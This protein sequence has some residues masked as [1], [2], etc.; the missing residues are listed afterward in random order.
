M[1]LSARLR[2]SA[3]DLLLG[4]GVTRAQHRVHSLVHDGRLEMF[5]QVDDPYSYLLL[6]ALPR[7]LDA[8][9]RLSVDLAVVPAPEVPLD[10]EPELR[11]RYA[12]R[13][14]AEIAARYDVVFP[15]EAEPIDPELAARAAA[16]LAVRRPDRE[17]LTLAIEVTATLW[18]RDRQDL[19][20]LAREHGTVND[21]SASLERAK[22]KQRRRGH[23]QGGMIRYGGTWYWGVDR[24]A[25]LSDDL[26]LAGHD[27]PAPLLRRRQPFPEVPA[28]EA[29]ELELFFSFR[30][31]YSYLALERV[32][33][34]ASRYGIPL[35]IKPVLPMVM[36]G[37]AVPIAKR[38]Y[39]ARDAAREA[40][41]LGIPFGRICDPLGGGVERCLA[42]FDHAE[43]KGAALSFC[44]SAARGIWSESLDMTSD[45][46]LAIVVRRAG[47]DWNEAKPWLF[48][49]GWQGRVETHRQQLR[50]LGLWGVPSFRLGDVAL[51]GQDRLERLEEHLNAWAVARSG[52][53]S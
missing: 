25:V 10:P 13:D 44:S 23:Y 1:G 42:L 32:G 12:I 16:I 33:M 45:D 4:D 24:L 17:Q 46:E 21:A 41:R 31:P 3:I 47:L 53:A 48:D 39:L 49:D 27:V 43:A 8:D 52:K 28:P 2:A 15:A 22:R 40:R 51:W 38:L 35:V 7:L 30:S 19:E 11:L 14:A 20:R 34:L 26:R 37:H 6:Q 5:H 18:A 50:E 9:D 36:R 29:N